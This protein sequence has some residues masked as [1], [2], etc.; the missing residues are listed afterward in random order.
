M[1]LGAP[2]AGGGDEHAPHQ[3]APVLAEE[4]VLGPAEADPLGPQGSRLG[5][6]LGGIGVCPHPQAAQLVRPAEHLGEVLADLGLDQRDL[7]GRDPAAGAL[8]CDRI[9]H[10]ELLLADPDNPGLGVDLD[11]GGAGDARTAHAAG[12]ERRV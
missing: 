1:D 11:L 7:V 5:R 8:D 4:H 9:P 6:V 3:L 12:D 2:P 10:G